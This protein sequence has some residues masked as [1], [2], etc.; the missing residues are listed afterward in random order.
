MVYARK[1]TCLH[2]TDF[3][4]RK[5]RIKRVRNRLAGVTIGNKKEFYSTD[6]LK[7]TKR[8]IRSENRAPGVTLANQGGRKDD[9]PD[10]RRNLRRSGKRHDYLVGR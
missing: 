9:L 3:E 2:A 1:V 5:G 6:I 8:G 7:R 4:K 10:N